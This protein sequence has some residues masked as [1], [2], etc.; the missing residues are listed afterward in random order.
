[1]DFNPCKKFPQAPAGTLDEIIVSRFV[2]HATRIFEA[3]ESTAAAGHVVSDMAILI[4]PE[5]GIRM[6]ADSDWPLESL[7]LE[8]GAQMAYRVTQ[9]LDSVRV[10]GRAGSRTCLFESEKPASVARLLS[11]SSPIY[12]VIPARALLA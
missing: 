12:D 8:H 1:V 5:G 11:P 6:I 7:R 2:E 9:H 3:A 4:G 10:E